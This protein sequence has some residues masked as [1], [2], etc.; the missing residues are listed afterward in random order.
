MP[1]PHIRCT[2]ICS[3]ILCHNAPLDGKEDSVSLG[4]P[5]AERVKESTP[6]KKVRL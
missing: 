4:Q 6:W 3:V 2:L 5:V 1:V